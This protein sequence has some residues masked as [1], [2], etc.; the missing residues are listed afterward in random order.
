V[1]E[2]EELLTAAAAAAAA[3]GGRDGTFDV[4]RQ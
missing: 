4:W 3:E 2:C 1:S